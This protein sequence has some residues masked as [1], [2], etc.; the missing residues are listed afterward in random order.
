MR[1]EMNNCVK[2][3]VR[4]MQIFSPLQDRDEIQSCYLS[5]IYRQPPCLG[6]EIREANALS[7]MISWVSHLPYLSSPLCSLVVNMSTPAE[8]C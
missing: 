1:R 6:P 2:K 4:Q 5:Q 7:F 8:K 3:P